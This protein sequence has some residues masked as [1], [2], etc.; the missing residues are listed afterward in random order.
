MRH[1]AIALN[2][3]LMAHDLDLG[4]DYYNVLKQLL[5]RALVA[6]KSTER[7]V[8]A[9]QVEI[10]RLQMLSVTDSATG[11][12][13]RRGFAESLERAL[14]RG[15]RYSEPAVLLLIDLDG[16]KPINYDYG[17]AAG[18][19]VLLVVAD[20]FKGAVRAVN[21]VSRI[22]GDEFA[23]VLNK[24]PHQR[25]DK[26]EMAIEKTLNS[27]VIPWENDEIQFRAS[28]GNQCFGLN[29]DDSAEIVYARAD[30]AMYLKKGRKH[31]LAAE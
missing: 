24:M 8:A 13:N 1:G 17:H 6:A 26:H 18:D 16:F 27:L 22:G 29:L 14:E 9:Q 30:N 20:R 21:D 11:L 4:K 15:R 10:D 2:R 28:V 25:A 3:N 19:F 23:I 12:L 7:K 31:A 5:Q